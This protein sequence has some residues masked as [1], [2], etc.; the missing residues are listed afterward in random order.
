MV[1]TLISEMTRHPIFVSWMKKKWRRHSNS[2]RILRATVTSRGNF[3]YSSP[4]GL[5]GHRDMSGKKKKNFRL[6]Q[7]FCFGST[8]TD[9]INGFHTFVMFIDYDP[10]MTHSCSRQNIN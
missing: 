7:L 4:R 9:N 1:E 2:V 5:I 10:V 3:Q 6:N 8:K